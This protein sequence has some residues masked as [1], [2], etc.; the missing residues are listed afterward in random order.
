MIKKIDLI[1]RF[2]K[3]HGDK[4]NY[5]LVDYRGMLKNIKI[6]C[7]KH[8]IFEQLPN[9]HLSGA[10]CPICNSVK[11]S[12]KDFFDRCN[13]VHNN[14]YDYSMSDFQGI[15][16][17]MKIFCPEHGEFEQRS[18]NH[19]DGQKCPFCANKRWDNEMFI[20]KAKE[21][22]GDKY[23]YSLVNYKNNHVKVI[24]ICPKHGK[25]EQ[26]PHNHIFLKRGCPYCARNKSNLEMAKAK[27]SEIHK[28]KYDYSLFTEYINVK[29]KIRII[30]PEHGEFFQ[31]LN[32][33]LNG[34]GC[35]VCL[36]TKGERKIRHFLEEN[37]IKFQQY[38]SFDGCRYKNPLP[39]DFYLSEL[40]ICIEYDGPQHFEPVTYFGGEERLEYTIM[41]DKIKNKFCIDND[42]K[43]IRIKYN[44]N[45]YDKLN[46]LSLMT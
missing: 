6:I 35:P 16:K 4:Y 26:L 41:L 3:V 24:I 46:F 9:N 22:H 44:E 39:F 28:N 31:K 37:N 25:F 12:S 38:K 43:L 33:H 10:G 17:K 1:N 34:Q 32:N 27:A 23:D 20:Q 7:P 2:R 29:Q 15:A 19:L 45:L 21:V 13:I 40:N 42:I 18:G 11:I 14:F 36:E 5:D 8:G 30:C